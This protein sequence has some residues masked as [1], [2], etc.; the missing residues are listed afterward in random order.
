MIVEILYFAEIKDITGREREKFVVSQNMG[1]LLH[2]L[3]E[4]YKSLHDLIWNEES[5][6]IH[7]LISVII[8]NQAIHQNDPSQIH[9]NNGDTIA[10]LLPVSGG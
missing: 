7:N 10:F 4:K 5:Q 6:K 1:D 9:L 3:F 2:V 8:N